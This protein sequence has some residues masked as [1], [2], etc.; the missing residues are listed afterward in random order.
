MVL[1]V[2]LVRR[3]LLAIRG[4]QD[5]SVL[6]VRPVHSATKVLLAFR[7]KLARRVLKV[8]LVR[9]VKWVPRV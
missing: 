9:S 2:R 8:H 3:A 1:L 6:L 5:Q 7:V 4:R